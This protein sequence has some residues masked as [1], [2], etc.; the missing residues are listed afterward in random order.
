M[1]E[2]QIKLLRTEMPRLLA[3]DRRMRA[4]AKRMEMSQH[5]AKKSVDKMIDRMLEKLEALK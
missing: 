4:R 5:S 3:L 2:E 1:N